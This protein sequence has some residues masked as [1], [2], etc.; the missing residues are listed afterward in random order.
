MISIYG[1]CQA[2]EILNMLSLSKNFVK[3]YGSESYTAMN[4]I[5]IKE[6]NPI[7]KIIENFKKTMLL[8]YQPLPEKHY[9]YSTDHLLEY[10]PK[11]CVKISFPYIFNDAI[12]GYPVDGNYKDAVDGDFDLSNEY[13]NP[14]NRF[15]YNLEITKNKEKTTVLKISDFINENY[16]DMELFY[17]QNHL[18]PVVIKELCR[19]VLEYL[20]IENDLYDINLETY[21]THYGDFRWPITKKA[22]QQFEFTYQLKYNEL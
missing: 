22:K 5:F 3:K 16:R 1:N 14:L 15:K 4:F 19:Q 18:N 6:H 8:I 9:P 10:L 20:Q 13:E 12:W 7:D 11:E 17:T 21:K 2:K